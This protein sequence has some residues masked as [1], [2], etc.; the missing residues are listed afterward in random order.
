MKGG[1]A[2]RVASVPL[3]GRC[4]LQAL[5]PVGHVHLNR[6]ASGNTRRIEFGIAAGRWHQIVEEVGIFSVFLTN[7]GVA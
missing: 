5:C 3:G 4:G 6:R 7:V 2:S 1:F